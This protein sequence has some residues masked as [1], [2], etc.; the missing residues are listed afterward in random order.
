MCLKREAISHIFAPT[1][2][3]IILRI[4]DAIDVLFLESN[5]D[6]HLIAIHYYKSWMQEE[7]NHISV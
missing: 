6:L 1:S 5:V 2:Q 3:D 4:N 7:A